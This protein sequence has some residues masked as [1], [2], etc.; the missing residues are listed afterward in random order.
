MRLRSV[1]SGSIGNL[2]EWYD[3]GLFAIYSP[4]FSRLFFP[5]SDPHVA[6]LMTLGVLAIGFLA[7]PIGALVFGYLGDSRGRALTLRLSI[8]MISIPTLLIAFLPTYASIGIAAP[9]LLLFIRIWQGVS[10]GGEYSGN[11]IYLTEMAPK[12]FRATITSFAATGANLGILLASLVSAICSYLFSDEFFQTIG[13]RIP[14]LLSGLLSIFIF[15]T[16]LQMQE[17]PVFTHLT[18]K[19]LLSVN[20]IRTVLQTNLPYVLRTVGLSCM[21]STFYYLCFIYMPTFL[22]ENLHYSLRTASAL[23]TFFIGTMVIMVPIAGLLCDAIGR[24]KMLLF[25][26]AFI[27][28]IAIPG[29]YFL[30]GQKD[31]IVFM[32]LGIFTI[33]SSLEQA[34]TGVSVVENYPA[35]VRYTGL[36]I[37]YNISNGL[38]GGTAPFVC[39]WLI[40][41]THILISPAIYIVI[42]ACITGLVSL[43]FVKETRECS[44]W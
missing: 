41:K 26:A 6:L 42:C 33:A 36:S 35:K 8:L 4:L 21:G 3:F 1:I 12:H 5:N 15:V 19:H 9:L 11:L 10:L 38:F 34:T 40:D 14:Y 13:W 25:N 31:I 29:F 16:R 23:M 28:V 18:K 43:F 32:V 37:G 7:R 39:Q 2:L 24:K 30:L 22:L 20:P 17:T 44:L 27:A